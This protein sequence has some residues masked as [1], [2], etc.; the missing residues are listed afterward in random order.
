M[1]VTEG[2]GHGSQ[3]KLSGPFAGFCSPVKAQQ[4]TV[5]SALRNQLAQSIH[6]PTAPVSTCNVVIKE[7][8][9]KAEL[10]NCTFSRSNPLFM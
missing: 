5:S 4:Q 7:C 6:Q 3:T 10:S 2:C 8:W 1:G 9:V